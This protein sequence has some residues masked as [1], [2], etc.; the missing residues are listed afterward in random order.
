MT[1]ARH[2]LWCCRCACTSST[3]GMA[4][5][6]VFPEPVGAHTHTSQC[7]YGARIVGITLRCTA[8]SSFKDIAFWRCAR[9]SGLSH[10]FIRSTA[11]AVLPMLVE[12]VTHRGRPPDSIVSQARP[13]TA[14]PQYHSSKRRR[15]HDNS[16]GQ[17]RQQNK[18]RQRHG[19]VVAVFYVCGGCCRCYCVRVAG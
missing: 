13:R 5:A 11:T 12:C 16:K 7:R 6:N 10:S 17:L 19:R 14:P 1:S 4:Y 2:T 18:T 3:I 9:I 8:N 15:Y